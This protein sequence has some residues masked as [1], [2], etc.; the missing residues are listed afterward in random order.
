[1][2]L[3][4]CERQHSRIALTETESIQQKLSKLHFQLYQGNLTAEEQ[5]KVLLQKASLLTNERGPG[6]FEAAENAFAQA[7]ELLEHTT[8]T[9]TLNT[10]LINRAVNWMQMGDTA[11]FLYTI[12]SLK[13]VVDLQDNFLQYYLHVNLGD[14]HH[15]LAAYDKAKNEYWQGLH[16]LPSDHCNPYR[17]ILEC[18]LAEIYVNENKIDSL[19]LLIP[20]LELYVTCEH[21]DSTQARYYLQ[22]I[23]YQRA[24]AKRRT[25]KAVN[26][27]DILNLLFD[28][29]RYA[30]SFFDKEDDSHLGDLFDQ[31][32]HRI[33]HTYFQLYDD[34]IPK[35]EH[36][37]LLSLLHANSIRKLRRKKVLSAIE[38]KA[39]H[40]TEINRLLLKV[41]DFKN[42]SDYKD[43][44]YKRLYE[45]LVLQAPANSI[46]Y[47]SEVS[48]FIDPSLSYTIFSSYREHLWRV[49]YRNSTLTLE[50]LDHNQVAALGKSL[51]SGLT[52]K[53]PNIDSIAV[54]LKNLLF[55]G[56][57][58]TNV[59]ADPL[60]A[61]LPLSYILKKEVAVDYGLIEHPIKTLD[62]TSAL[63]YSYSDSLSVRQAN[64]LLY[65]E[66]ASGLKECEEIG[67]TL[68]IN[69]YRD[70]F[71]TAEHFL[72]HTSDADLLHITTHGIS[73]TAVRRDCYFVVNDANGD[74]QPFY[75][76]EI[77]Q[78][79]KLPSFVNLSTCDSGVGYLLDGAGTYSIASEFL[80]HGSSAVLKTLHPIDDRASYH[81]QTAL[82]QFW[83]QGL[84]LSESI[85]RARVT[86]KSSDLYS[87]PYYWS[88]FVLEGNPNL[89]LAD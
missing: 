47:T 23:Y 78:L 17:N 81:F 83:S 80:S 75:A 7:H 45:L 44:A 2:V 13:S 46:D 49:D 16:K 61:N 20:S 42:D 53:V 6:I 82:Y 64:N 32:T 60:T 43:P 11:R 31:N 50:R 70:E 1:M 56:A 52:N 39:E 74:P 4:S 41:N 25:D 22:D 48:L 19:E 27:T 26:N 35:V 69:V 29:R 77:S 33:L 85:G 67:K 28:R 8:D 88:G 10:L 87:H 65:I 68:R 30:T 66:L 36:N 71:F 12:D 73:N 59:V 84:S 57:S 51:H 79:E 89:Y 15:S 86:M 14:Y 72:A 3:Y 9:K 40:T 37:R 55:Q 5:G 38:G 54:E 18:Y 21:V 76:Y 63:I 58:P 62:Q 24:L 34:T